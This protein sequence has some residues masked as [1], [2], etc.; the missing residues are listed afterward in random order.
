VDSSY[1]LSYS[2]V[3]AGEF[4]V[5]L[6]GELGAGRPPYPVWLD[7][8]DIHAGPED[9]DRQLVE[10]IKLCSALLFV[11]TEDS[12]RD[13]SGCK[14]E[15]VA[16]LRYK[17]PVIPMRLH[18][19]AEPPFRLSSR[20][21]IDF[22][23]SFDAGL[24]RLREHLAWADS[25]AGMLEDLRARRAD[26][27]YELARAQGGQRRRIEDELEE[28][29]RRSEEQER[30]VQ[31][32]RS[33][34][35]QTD[36]RIGAGL[37]LERQPAQTV[38][39]DR[40]ARFINPPPMSAPA[41]F[42]D[43][44]VETQL[45]GAFLREDGP[46]VMT[47]VGRGGVGKTA[48][49]CRVL[50][51]LEQGRLPDDLGE[52]TVAGIVYLSPLGA[53]PV[54]FPNLFTD[55]CRL[56]P[57]DRAEPLLARYRHSQATPVELMRD[58]LD[59][60]PE[61]T[62]VVVLLDN[63]EDALDVE[64]SDLADEILDAAL[65]ALL[66][67][68]AHGVKVVITTRVA[69]TTLL[70]A[71]PAVQRRLD[72]DEGL[73]APFAEQ[74][75][76]GSD[77]DG[78]LGVRDAPDEMLA[79]AR[80][81]TRGLPRALEALVAIL[82]AD[83][84]TTLPELLA[85]SA[86]T[87]ENVV[88]AMVGEAFSRL[89]PAA[90]RVMQALAIYPSAVPAVAVDYLL[91]PFEPAIDSAPVLARLVN[92]GFARRDRGRHYLHQADRDYALSHVPTSKA[93]DGDSEAP[94]F[95]QRGLR[96]RAADYFREIRTP[97]ATW[98]GLDHV[99][100]QLAEF[101][102]RYQAGDYDGAHKVLRE[103]D[104][105]YLMVW[106]HY[107]L[108]V[109]LHERLEGLLKDPES[110]MMNKGS[111][112]DSYEHFGET[113]RAIELNE[114]ALAIVRQLGGPA[115]RWNEAAFLSNLGNCYSTLGDIHRAIELY[116]RAVPIHQQVGIRFNEATTLACLGFA[117]TRIGDLNRAIDFHERAL[118]IAE[119]GKVW[120]VY[121]QEDAGRIVEMT[122][123]RGLG[124]CYALLGDLGQ[125]IELYERALTIAREIG[126]RDAEA[127]ALAQL[128]D[129]HADSGAWPR[130][131]GY[132]EEAIG[133]ADEVG[134][135]DTRAAA[136]VSLARIQLHA[137]EIDAARET[138]Q[139]LPRTS[140]PSSAPDLAL[141]L[142]ILLARQDVADAADE[143]FADAARSSAELLDQ[144]RDNYHA[145]DIQALALCGIAI[146]GE[147]ARLAEASAC[148]SAARAIIRAE[149]V[150]NRVLRLLDALNPRDRAGILAPI[151]R[152]AA[153]QD[154]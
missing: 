111:L 103:I 95:T 94:A 2:R 81:R 61:G 47:V 58:L 125:A 86:P 70:L 100:P 89:D 140:D 80:Q 99:S 23:S 141:T 120:L 133:I 53:H 147:R 91:Q 113:G 109:G 110:D 45:V 145:L 38:G 139:A 59:A 44:Y 78:R 84:D 126:D 1:F 69:P 93:S 153:G 79:R 42:Q 25:P 66:S 16:A 104:F 105:D 62:P 122:S 98:R 13:Q 40:R 52:L 43:R 8:R 67:A 76:R 6:A 24:A 74:V 19:A 127:K 37:Q 142:G 49:V 112:A 68:P 88:E 130:A 22:S 138:L 10:A 39:A 106:G 83:R 75:L 144:A 146:A 114:Q 57:A 27:E 4:A 35:E 55:L 60:F 36:A 32:P 107:A 54:N 34:V 124:M 31:A 65:R 123:R 3:D 136:R 29:R 72:L 26:A 11:M 151:R 15:W 9:W 7:V 134:G 90:Q 28:L 96:L 137:G 92:M 21:F 101:E 143:A 129:C 18:D 5:R 121:R 118:A 85:D 131:A 115:G 17:K 117:Q 87:P 51:A 48:M 82:A 20:Q 50:K 128:G 148:F 33:V 63:F 14:P 71:Q 46:R 102:L 56:L 97:P 12:V 30:I 77:P 149:G 41:Y 108:S 154:R 73:P 116:E 150:V 152:T 119:T 132:C 64:T 135:A